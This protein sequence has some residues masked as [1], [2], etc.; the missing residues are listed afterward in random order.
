[1]FRAVV[2]LSMICLLAV[3]PATAQKAVPVK[4]P[5]PVVGPAT[6]EM[7]AAR[8]IL[9]ACTEVVATTTPQ[10]LEEV[11]GSIMAKHIVVR[12]QLESARHD[13][14]EDW[15]GTAERFVSRRSWVFRLMMEAALTASQFDVHQQIQAEA[16]KPVVVEEL[17]KLI[18]LA[19]GDGTAAALDNPFLGN[20]LQ[21]N[22]K[23]DEALA[24]ELEAKV[25]AI[26]ARKRLV[27]HDARLT[28]ARMVVIGIKTCIDEQSAYLEA[29]APDGTQVAGVSDLDEAGG[30][31]MDRYFSSGTP[32]RTVEMPPSLGDIQYSP[33]E[34]HNICMAD[35][36]CVAWNYLYPVSGPAQCEILGEAGDVAQSERPGQDEGFFAFSG[37]GPKS[38]ELGL[39]RPD[40]GI[41]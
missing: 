36:A 16:S 30:Y 41:D 14:M 25:E 20:L 6:E 17:G 26:V 24:G 28:V 40:D 18:D 2:V 37:F 1:M 39:A 33:G 19:A 13:L 38:I 27:A 9:N 10:A 5:P 8:T 22:A 11:S 23:I 32:L 34:C 3:S 21:L 15:V 29:A 4:E 35:S 12:D 7:V 31:R